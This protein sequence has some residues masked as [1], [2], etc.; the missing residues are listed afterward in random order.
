MLTAS[1]TKRHCAVNSAFVGMESSAV[2]GLVRAARRACNAIDLRLLGGGE[3][4]DASSSRSRAASPFLVSRLLLAQH[5]LI[6]VGAF[7]PR[8]SSNFVTSWLS[9]GR[10]S[11]EA[12]DGSDRREASDGLARR[13]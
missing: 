7:R 6:R 2:F 8:V 9:H 5:E 4:R 11:S 12:M 1:C 13:D 3:E 10:P